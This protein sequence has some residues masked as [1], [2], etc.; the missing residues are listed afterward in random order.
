MPPFSLLFLSLS[1]YLLRC[2]REEGDG[3][4]TEDKLEG[5]SDW[6]R[7]VAWCPSVGLPLSR[8]ASCSQVREVRQ[9]VRQRVRG[10]SI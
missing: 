6:V 3:W 4:V 1:P 10:M 7:D 9:R 8:I 2:V 5:H